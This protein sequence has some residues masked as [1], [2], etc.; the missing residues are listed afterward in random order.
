[1]GKGGERINVEMQENEELGIHGRKKAD[2]RDGKK[3]E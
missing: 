2:S 3:G 1:M